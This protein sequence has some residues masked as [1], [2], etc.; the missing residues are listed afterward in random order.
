[1]SILADGKTHVEVSDGEKIV[2]SRNHRLSK[3]KL[4]RLVEFLES[5]LIKG[6]PEVGALATDSDYGE[7]VLFTEGRKLEMT[8]QGAGEGRTEFARFYR[9]VRYLEWH[10]HIPNPYCR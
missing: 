9:I 6:P 7:I 2:F 8:A 1:M 10:L 3:R 5:E 4:G